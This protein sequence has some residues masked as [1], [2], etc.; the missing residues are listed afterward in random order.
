MK[1]AFP[2]SIATLFALFVRVL[3]ADEPTLPAVPPSLE[4]VTWA[5]PSVT[6]GD[7]RGKSVVVLAYVT[8]YQLAVDWPTQCLAELKLAAQDKPVVI[9]AIN[10]DKKAELDLSYMKARDFNGPNILHG[11]DPLLPARMGLKSAFFQYVWIDPQ[12]KVFRSG[13]A[14]S[15]Y[16]DGAEP[17][18]A[19]ARRISRSAGLGQFEIIEAQMPAKIKRLLWPYE[20]GRL[21][22]ASDLQ[23]LRTGLDEEEQKVVD[24]A[25]DRYLDAEVKRIRAGA[26]GSAEERL[27]AFE[28]AKRLY[29]TFR[30]RTQAEDFKELGSQLYQDPEFKKE[31]AARQAYDKAL[32]QSAATR[33]AAALRPRLMQALARQYKDTFYGELAAHDGKAVRPKSILA[34]KDFSEAEIQAAVARQKKF[35]DEVS[36]K[37]PTAGMQSYET[38]RFLFY[39]DLPPQIIND[40]Y[41]P[42]LD[43]MYLQLCGAYGFDAGKSIWRGKA[44]IVAFANQ[45]SFQQFELDFYRNTKPGAQ[46]IAHCDLNKNV[47]ISCYAGKDPEYF[48]VVLVHETAHGFSWCYKSAESLPN[49]LNE[50]ASEWIAHRVVT[51]DASIEKKIQVAMAAMRKSRSL[52]GDFFTIDHIHAWQYGAAASITDFLLNYEPSGRPAGSTTRAAGRVSRYRKLIDGIKEGLPWEEALGEAYGMDPIQLA[53]AYGQSIGIPDLQP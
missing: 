40:R 34:W 27:S 41:L 45:S 53:R 44:I 1:L 12:G 36:S 9:L 29:A 22:S 31:L 2:C 16:S 10:T 8:K 30:T 18:F 39:S 15:Q 24:V 52:G 51:G 48:A 20:L 6:L 23:K 35:I 14:G 4:G 7:L 26:A 50:G 32:Q 19:L 46:G 28:R 13:S 25:F 47:V 5:G 38:R 3:L 17:R 49:W 11:R 33:D 42:Y 43:S 37:V 21:P